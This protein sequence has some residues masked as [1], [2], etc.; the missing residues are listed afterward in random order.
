MGACGEVVDA[1]YEGAIGSVGVEAGEREV[2]DAA[3]V[4]VGEGVA[5]WAAAALDFSG[6]SFVYGCLC[7]SEGVS[8]VF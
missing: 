8:E 3:E 4:A 6:G 5:S 1:G 2:C 7:W